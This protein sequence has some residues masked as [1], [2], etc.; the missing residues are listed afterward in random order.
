LGL[1]RNGTLTSVLRWSSTGLVGIGTTGPTARLHVSGAETSSNGR[2]A[3][4]RLE[5]TAATTPNSWIFRAGGAG[6]STPDGGFSI[7][8]D[9]NYRLKITS[10]GNVGIGTTNPAQK[11]DVNGNVRI[12]GQSGSAQ[13]MLI[14]DE[15]GD[16]QASRHYSYSKTGTSSGTAQSQTY[17]HNLGYQP[18]WL[19]SIESSEAEPSLTVSYENTSNNQTVFRVYNAGIGPKNCTIH[20]IPVY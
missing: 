9:N 18:V 6:T 2:N 17:T 12:T 20:A 1:N 19:L 13:R 8:D 10:T 3:A 4:F 7:A 14:A 15:Q 5:N 11:L 16:V